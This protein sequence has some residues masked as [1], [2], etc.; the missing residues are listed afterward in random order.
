MS[1]VEPKVS[2]VIVTHDAR[3]ELERCL[4]SIAD[5]AAV[6]TETIVVDN[7]STDDTIEWARREHP[8]ARLVELDRNV[9][10]AARQDGLA[11]ARGE[12]IM[13]LDSDAALTDGALPRMVTAM[14]ENPGWGLIGPRLVHDDGTLQLSCR[15]YPPALLPLLSRRP[16]SLWFE[17]SAPVR[18]HMMADDDHDHVRPVLWVLGACQLFR[19]SL[20]RRAGRF[21]PDYFLGPD[22][23]DWCI[24]I[25][26][27]GGEIMYFPEATV[28]H[29]YR[30]TSRRRPLSRA[31]VEQIR[32]WARFQW[33]YRDRRRE[34]IQLADELDRR[35]SPASR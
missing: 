6:E 23:T 16:L 8:E 33:D 29:S 22:D 25:R 27:A 9:G 2:I 30:R 5:H 28:I 19:A 4:A 15:R 11:I 26:D 35:S 24:R 3:T 10:V 12:L 17:D 21:S 18:R 20:A 32:G 13:F 31:T 1:R 7:A 34:L 14:E